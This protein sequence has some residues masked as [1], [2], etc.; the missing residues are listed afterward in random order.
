MRRVL[1]LLTA[2]LIMGATAAAV[3]A[4]GKDWGGI[5]PHGH[6]MLLGG[7]IDEQQGTLHFR[8]C[9]EFA[10]GVALP[11]RA[12]HDSVHTGA[13]GGSPF[14]QGA[15]WNAGNIVVPLAPFG[16]PDWTGCESFESGMA[17]PM[18]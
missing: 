5:P 17:L 7:E 2:V 10:A 15:L 14:V 11:N 1:A 9:V 16:P 12:H 8:R 13:A 4:Q 6:V 3:S 18:P